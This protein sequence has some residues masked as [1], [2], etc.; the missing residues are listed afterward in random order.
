MK[1]SIVYYYKVLGY[2]I[3]KIKS[4]ESCI[5]ILY[6]ILLAKVGGYDIYDEVQGE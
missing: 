2:G 6:K 1:I 5:K 4:G 3:D